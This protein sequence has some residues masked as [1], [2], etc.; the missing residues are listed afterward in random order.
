V[1]GSA[2]FNRPPPSSALGNYKTKRFD[3]GLTRQSFTS[4]W[5]KETADTERINK[6]VITDFRNAAANLRLA[7]GRGGSQGT[8]AL[9]VLL[10]ASDLRALY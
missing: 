9:W 4:G 3:T 6:P 8:R 2:P 5:G 7:W 10:V 1:P